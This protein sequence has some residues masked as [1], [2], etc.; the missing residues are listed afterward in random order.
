MAAHNDFGRAAESRAAAHLTAAGWEI[1]HRNWRWHHKEVDLVARRGDI[2]AFVEVRAR[3]SARC[4]HPAETIS[5]R[6]QRDLAQAAQAWAASHGR[7][8]DSYRF[9]VVTILG[10]ASPQHLEAA[11]HL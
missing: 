5:P 10:T 8:H 9:D 6:K 4:G 2:V 1:V 3:R 7:P 11:W